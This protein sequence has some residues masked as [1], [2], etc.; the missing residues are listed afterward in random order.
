MMNCLDICR[1]CQKRFVVTRNDKGK[2]SFYR[3]VD[4]NEYPDFVKRRHQSSL[5]KLLFALDSETGR[6]LSP[7]EEFRDL[8]WRPIPYFE[9]RKIR[10]DDRRFLRLIGED[11]ENCRMFPEM[12]MARWNND[13]M[14]S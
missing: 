11:I 7:F 5:M 2:V 3:C 6:F 9:K 14:L 8:F 4:R 13:R 10:M 12:Q 1:K